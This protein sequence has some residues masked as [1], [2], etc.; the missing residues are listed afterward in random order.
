[1]SKR[2]DNKKLF[3]ILGVLVI[4]LLLTFVLKVPRENATLKGLLVDLD[5][6]AVAKIVLS[7]KISTGEPFEFFREK[8]RWRVRQ[9]NIIS[10]PVQGAIQ[11]IF[12]EINSIKPQ[13]LASVDETRW[14]EFELTDSLATRV[15]F[16]NSKGKVLT[17]ILIGK[18]S[19]KQ[20]ANPY[21]YSG[22]NNIEGTSY[23]R[24]YGEKEVYAVDGF[25]AFTFNGKFSDWRD[26]TLFRC[27]KDDILKINFN[28]P[29][30]SSYTLSKKESAWFADDQKADSTAV[31]NYLN[32]VENISGIDINDNFKPVSNPEYQVSF[33]G[34]NLLNVSVKCYAGEGTDDYILNSNLNP[35]VF[36]TSKK[37][38]VFS[39]I[40]KSKKYF[41][42]K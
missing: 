33:E 26:K 30:D 16:L 37:S 2:F 42:K 40:V 12:N 20:I 19:Y 34:N 1:M 18:L 27:R 32:S 23:V 6:T 17:D 41:V 29:G 3:Y 13:S 14:K 39:Q 5:T 8:N 28:L 21:G 36:F 10:D 31:S 35:E 38:G 7:P 4:A 24:I 9:G 15:K 11:N 25:L 22:G